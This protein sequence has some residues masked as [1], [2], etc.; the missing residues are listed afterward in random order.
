MNAASMKF[1]YVPDDSELEKASNSYVMSLL[2][3]MVGMPL[4]I[5]NLIATFIF[6]VGNRNG[7]YFVRWHCTQALFS[8]LFVLII[9]SIGLSWTLRILFSDLELSNRYI[10]YMITLFIFNLS[11]IIATIYAAQKTRKGMHVNFWFFGTLTDLTC[12]KR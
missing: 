6:F 9:N 2:A 3:I 1:D 11:E 12:R 8:Q 4:P 7:S 10:G 5:I